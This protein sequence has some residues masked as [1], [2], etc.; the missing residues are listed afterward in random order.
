MSKPFVQLSG[1]DGNVFSIIARVGR[2]L[3]DGDD[4]EKAEEF[5][6]KAFAAKSYGE[7][8]HLVEEYCKI[9]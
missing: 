6:A 2:T 7:V 5:I 3:R 4:P 9:G 1:K 8:L